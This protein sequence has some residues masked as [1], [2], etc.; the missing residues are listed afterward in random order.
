MMQ[1]ALDD[2]ML[3]LAEQQKA[4]KLDASTRVHSILD[5]L[6]KLSIERLRNSAFSLDSPI[7]L[8]G[9]VST[10]YLGT[11]LEKAS[12]LSTQFSTSM[13]DY[14]S[15][16]MQGEAET[17]VIRDLV[18][19]TDSV[20]VIFE[21]VKAVAADR[22]DEVQDILIESSRDLAKLVELFLESLFS[23]ELLSVEL[24]ERTDKVINGNINVQEILQDLMQVIEVF[25][26]PVI[27]SKESESLETMLDREFANTQAVIE[28]AAALLDDMS[29]K[30]QLDVQEGMS[31][32]VNDAILSSASSIINA[33]R[34]LLQACINAQKEIV[35]QG[36]GSQSRA[37]FYKKNNRWTEGL[38]S[39]SKQVAYATGVLIR[40]ADGVLG[41]KNTSEELIV[42]SNEVAASTAQLVSSSRV[43]SDY[44]SKAHMDLEA[45]SKEV[46][47]CCKSLVAKV[48]SLLLVEESASSIDY[49][50]LSTHENRTAELEQQVE[51][52]KLESALSLAR[53][54]LGEIRKFSYIEED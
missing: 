30:A 11:M 26:S 34:A 19:F 41:G 18:E 36:K 2:A 9:S 38:I 25:R 22:K 32:E 50:Q 28:K 52:L 23:T 10:E 29:S 27:S 40:I 24:E 5:T 14:I 6:L 1:Q 39:A 8:V 42:A 13:T 33:I 37:S 47:S 16:D 44:M 15:D 51:I 45:A 4:V 31:L 20:D 7:N 17:P 54:R 21:C 3:E 48:K 35:R 46:N 12:H 49:S 43:K 53:K